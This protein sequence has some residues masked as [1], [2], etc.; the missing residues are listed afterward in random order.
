MIRQ[1]TVGIGALGLVMV[2]GA[3][4][5]NAV[6][7]EDEVK[8]EF[9][10]IKVAGKMAKKAVMVC[11]KLVPQEGQDPSACVSEE[12]LK[13]DK[14][15]TKVESVYDTCP[16]SF[17]SPRLQSLIALH[18]QQIADVGASNYNSIPCAAGCL[19]G[20]TFEV[21]VGQSVRVVVDTTD[22]GKGADLSLAVVCDT[23]TPAPA[24]DDMPCTY[25]ATDGSKCPELK[26]N[27][28]ADQSCTVNVI[29]DG[30]CVD[31]TV[32]YRMRVSTAGHSPITLVQTTNDSCPP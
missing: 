15:M 28:T 17:D 21:A 6:A 8:C 22:A 9:Q 31:T 16:T 23:D 13:L 20:W 2:L 4:A 3:Q 26:F 11:H 7:L 32:P 24:D 27:S 5:A 30:A 12:Q 19:D 25:P 29:V 10:K 18:S 14:S 1:I